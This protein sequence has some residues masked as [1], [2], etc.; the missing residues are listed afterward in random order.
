MKIFDLFN[1]K[2]KVAIV[3]GGAGYLG[4]S[5]AE[6]L[7]EAGAD[8]YI[9]SRNK[10][11]GEKAVVKLRET[12]NG[13][14]QSLVLDVL[15]IDSIKSSFQKIVEDSGKIDILVNNASYMNPSKFEYISEAEWKSGIDGTI[16]GVFRCTNEVIP[17]MEK[18]GVGS[19]INIAS[20]YG[21]V[22]PDPSIYGDSGL[23]SP[24]YY[25]AG[26]AA[27]LQYTRHMACHLAKKNIRV[28]AISPGPFPKP[29]VQQDI[30]FINN[31]KN[32]T[33]LGRIGQPSELKGIIVFLAS[34][35]S[36]FVTGDNIHIDGGWSVW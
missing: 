5:M 4:M 35:A 1:L 7:V 6:A 34:E 23:N 18:N 20:M 8:V 12:V 33:P 11:K 15:S 27:I 22:S 2:N 10:E 14:I 19:I 26:K 29:E 24:P 32:K 36:S 13:K 16:N 28:N 3:T 9:T 17:I 21:E 30:E 31:L 25:G